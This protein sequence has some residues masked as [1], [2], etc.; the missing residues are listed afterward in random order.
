MQHRLKESQRI[1]KK[2]IEVDMQGMK[3]E[4]QQSIEY[5]QHRENVDEAKK[6]AVKQLM[7]YEN[8][9]QMVL[10]ADLK[11]LKT[12]EVKE[13]I[14]FGGPYSRKEVILNHANL[15]KNKNELSNFNQEIMENLNSIKNPNK[16]NEKEAL[17]MDEETLKNE[18]SKIPVPKNFRE[19]KKIFKKLYNRDKP[20][21]N[22]DLSLLIWLTLQPK[23]YYKRIYSVNFEIYYFV[24]IIDILLEWIND[25]ERWKI[26]RNYFTWFLD[27]LTDVSNLSNFEFGLKSLFGKTESILLRKLLDLIG[28]KNENVVDYV[29]DLKKRF[30]Q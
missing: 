4:L 2:D 26:R 7:D 10:G 13:L 27:F 23:T 14:E 17:I 21:P 11:P 25:E 24:N 9:H 8:F 29:E 18:L 22:S 20:T 12:G 5:E 28:E 1:F 19:Y 16:S 30:K 3:N 15:N 6:R